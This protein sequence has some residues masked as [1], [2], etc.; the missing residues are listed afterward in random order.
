MARIAFGSR[1]GSVVLLA[2][3]AAVVACDGSPG[4][5]NAPS[6]Q[7]TI[8][9]TPASTPRVLEDAGLETTMLPGSY[10]SRL[11]EPA[12]RLELGEGWFRRDVITDRALDIRHGASGAESMRLNAVV[13]FLQCGS[14]VVAKPDSKLL[15]ATIAATPGMRA[16]QPRPVKVGNRDAI[17]IRLQGGGEPIP[18]DELFA[19][20]NELGCVVTYGPAPWPADG[21]WMFLNGDTVLQL[22]LL[23][24]GSTT[25]VVR[26]LGDDPEG[27]F[28]DLV[29]EVL[30]SSSIG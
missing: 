15:A 5:A 21:G 14:E 2:C 13:D 19:R 3:L 29:L 8:A 20:A 1:Y 24:V 30:A 23:D 7:P 22:V 17:E 28:F 4:S 25:V 27:R 26:S 18:E 9:P 10:V 6:A 11:F 16:T 12:V